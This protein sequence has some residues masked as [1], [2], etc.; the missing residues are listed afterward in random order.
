MAITFLLLAWVQKDANSHMNSRPLFGKILNCISGLL[1]LIELKKMIQ[2]RDFKSLIINIFCAS[3]LFYWGFRLC[4][5][6]CLTCLN[7]G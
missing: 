3:F 6:V 4:S 1:I 5:I 7:S 2:K